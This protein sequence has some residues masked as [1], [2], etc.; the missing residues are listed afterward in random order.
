MYYICTLTNGYPKKTNLKNKG[1]LAKGIYFW[2]CLLH[3]M[4]INRIYISI[5]ESTE[6]TYIGS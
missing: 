5:D 6:G 1:G 3:K 2:S 4:H